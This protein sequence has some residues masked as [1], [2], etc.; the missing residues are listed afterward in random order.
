MPSCSACDP[1]LLTMTNVVAGVCGNGSHY[2]TMCGNGHY[3]DTCRPCPVC[4]GAVTG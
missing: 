3:Y 1:Q 2:W 4:A